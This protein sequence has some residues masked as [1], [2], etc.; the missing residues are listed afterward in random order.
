MDA[1]TLLP[2]TWVCGLSVM[3]D[4]CLSLQHCQ[5]VFGLV[6][7][8]V[9]SFARLNLKYTSQVGSAE[10]RVLELVCDR[11]GWPTI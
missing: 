9:L 6:L 7:D 2:L 4:G 1:P 8:R 3:K 10:R 5:S 11:G